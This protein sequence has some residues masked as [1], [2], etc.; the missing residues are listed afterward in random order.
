[1][2]HLQGEREPGRPTPGQMLARLPEEEEQE[3]L[4]ESSSP[5]TGYLRIF[6][7]AVGGDE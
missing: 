7:C 4:P 6:L 1:M 2:S 5:D 3:E